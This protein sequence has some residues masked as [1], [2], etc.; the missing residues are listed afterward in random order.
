LATLLAVRESNE[1][2]LDVVIG[3]VQIDLEL[4]VSPLVDQDR[5]LQQLQVAVALVEEDQCEPI[6]V[7]EVEL[8]LQNPGLERRVVKVVRISSLRRN[9]VNK[10]ME[11]VEA[12]FVE[13][14]SLVAPMAV[15]VRH[16]IPNLKPQQIDFLLNL[17]LLVYFD[18]FCSATEMLHN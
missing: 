18:C 3:F 17:V 15:V 16:S 11:Q 4:E 7:E 12:C 13:I 10:A 1:A 5:I 14:D 9:Y 8:L 6:L 2:L